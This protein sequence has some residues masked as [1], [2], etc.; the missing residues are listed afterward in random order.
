MDLYSVVILHSFSLFTTLALYW[1]LH[2]D[3]NWR[4]DVILWRIFCHEESRRSRLGHTRSTPSYLGP[5][6]DVL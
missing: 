2:C 4:T 3:R 6:F 5:I 1:V